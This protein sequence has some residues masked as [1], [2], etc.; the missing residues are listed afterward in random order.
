M[1]ACVSGCGVCTE[2]RLILEKC[3]FS[4]DERKLPEVGP[5]GPKHVAANYF[6]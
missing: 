6:Y 1:A 4:Q 2:C 5:G 3:N